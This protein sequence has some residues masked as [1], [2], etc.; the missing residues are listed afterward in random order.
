M[1]LIRVTSKDT[2]V[3][4]ARQNQDQRIRLQRDSWQSQFLRQSFKNSRQFN[5][6]S[7]RAR[8]SRQAGAT[9]RAANAITG[10]AISLGLATECLNVNVNFF[11][12]M[13]D[14]VRQSVLLGVSDAI[15]QLGTPADSDEIHPGV[16]A[17][18]QS[19]KTEKSEETKRVGATA[20]PGSG[21]NRKR[22][23]RSLKDIDQSAAA[24]S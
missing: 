3:L 12:W 14:G 8:R 10:I 17:F 21:G 1:K 5:F 13:R 6:R 24:A 7:I 11:E 16:A 19:D 9:V 23:G 18:L 22:L 15:E 4:F 20:A 2:R